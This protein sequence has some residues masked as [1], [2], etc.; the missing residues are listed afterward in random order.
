MSRSSLFWLLWGGC[1]V[2]SDLSTLPPDPGSSPEPAPTAA[3]S[4]GPDWLTPDLEVQASELP[5]EVD[6]AGQDGVIGAPAW[7]ADGRRLV[8]AR[9]VG[10]AFSTQLVVAEWRDGAWVEQVLVA[11][12]MPDR[13]ALSPDGATVAWFASAGGF[14]ALFVGSFDGSTRVQLTNKDL[15]RDKI[16]GPP[17]GFVPPP[18]DDSLA[19]DGD[20]LVWDSPDG[21][22]SVPWR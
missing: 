15:R 11:D 3:P 9:R 17:P 22:Q 14:P 18:Y 13:P 21:P 1:V 5:P 16:I 6:V 19:F 10:G 2:E 20:R 8:A 7:S 4:G 12:G